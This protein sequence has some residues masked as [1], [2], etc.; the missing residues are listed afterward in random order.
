MIALL[1]EGKLE[2][3]AHLI[4]LL[5]FLLEINFKFVGRETHFGLS[6]LVCGA[7]GSQPRVLETLS[8]TGSA[9]AEFESH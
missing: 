4:S 7:M 3:G 6:G 5:L 2:L 9:P 1:E 8:C